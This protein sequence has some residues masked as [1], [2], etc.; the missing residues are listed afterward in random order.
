MQGNSQR[1]QANT[2]S[3]GRGVAPVQVRRTYTLAR[4]IDRLAHTCM[5]AHCIGT[6]KHTTKRPQ[7][8]STHSIHPPTVFIHP[9]SSFFC[10]FAIQ[11]KRAFVEHVHISTNIFIEFFSA[12][13][14]PL[15][16]LAPF[17]WRFWSFA[18]L[19]LQ[20][21]FLALLASLPVSDKEGS[22]HATL[23]ANLHPCSKT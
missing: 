15:F 18:L 8:S 1:Q 16:Y 5:H 9:Q 13:L 21:V 17:P 12:L 11:A 7:S 6:C 19:I 10:L 23:L 22:K 4:I 20:C 14:R 2:H 3:K